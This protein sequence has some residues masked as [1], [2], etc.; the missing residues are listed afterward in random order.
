[1][2][3]VSNLRPGERRSRC[4]PGIGHAFHPVSRL[5]SGKVLCS[6]HH[7]VRD[8]W[9]RTGLHLIVSCSPSPSTSPRGGGPKQENHPHVSSLHKMRRLPGGGNEILHWLRRDARRIAG[10]GCPIA[11]GGVPS[12]P[13][14]PHELG[15][16]APTLA[17]APAATGPIATSGSPLLK[18]V[19]AVVALLLFCSLLGI[20]ACVFM[21]YRIKRSVNQIENH[22]QTRLHR[23]AG[24]R[25]LRATD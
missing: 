11:V 5:D 3:P 7:A 1:V 21:V 15:L 8:Y 9:P 17:Q 22:A 4:G 16:N 13:A 18:M 20:G 25:E 2:Y 24:T 6:A 23:P 12:S 19:F 14:T 10:P